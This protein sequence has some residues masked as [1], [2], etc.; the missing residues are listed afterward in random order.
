MK[1]TLVRLLL[2]AL[3]AVGSLLP[4]GAQTYLTT[5]TLASAVTSLTTSTIFLTSTSGITA[6][7]CGGSVQG[8]GLF[9]DREYMTVTSVPVSGQVNVTRGAASGTTASTHLTGRVVI[10]APQS[11][12]SGSDYDG[13][14]GRSPGG[15]CTAT[16]AR[17]LPVVNITNGN[18]WLC[19][20]GVASVNG[21]VTTSSTWVATNTAPITY[22]SLMTVLP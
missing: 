14:T 2:V 10:I 22:N 9:V 19:R 3:L 5:T 12:F 20:P 1:N 21:S 6:A 18:V 15:P 8:C 7:Y 11:A 13:T 4:V 16:A 17:Y